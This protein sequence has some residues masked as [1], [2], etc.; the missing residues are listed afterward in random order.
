VILLYK[1]FLNCI[2]AMNAYKIGELLLQDQVTQSFK[3]HIPFVG[4][5]NAGIVL[6]CLQ[7]NNFMQ[8]QL[9]LLGSFFYKYGIATQCTS[10]QF[11]FV[12]DQ[13]VF[14]QAQHHFV[15]PIRGKWLY[16]EIKGLQIKAV[17]SLL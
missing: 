17:Q 15:K 6:H 13:K 7:E 10:E 1:I 9:N 2:T 3:Y 4:S 5:M 8:L 14:L 11:R 16:E 12:P